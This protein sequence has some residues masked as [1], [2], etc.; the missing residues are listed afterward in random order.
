MSIALL[1]M[2][3]AAVLFGLAAF[4]VVEDRPRFKPVPAGLLAL[5]LSVLL[6]PLLV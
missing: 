6:P 4:G 1:M 5:T 2:L 3:I